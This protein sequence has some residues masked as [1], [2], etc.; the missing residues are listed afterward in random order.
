MA[1]GA[2]PPLVPVLPSSNR[3]RIASYNIR[4]GRRWR[5]E[6]A[7]R[8]MEQMDVGLGFLLEAKITDG[9]YTRFSSD[10]HVV[11]TDAP[12]PHQGGIALFYKDSRRWHIESVRRHGSNVI[13][14]VLVT[15]TRR[16]GLVGAYV[17]PSDR[18]TL[19]FVEAA[20]DR[21]PPDCTPVVLGDLNVDLDDLRDDR[22]HEI[23][24]ALTTRN[25]EDLLGHF[26]QRHRYRHCQ[27]WS[28]TRNGEYISSRCDYILCP[29]RQFFLNT[30]LRSPRLFDSDYLL[31]LA[32]LSLLP[33]D[34]HR[35]YT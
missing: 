4:N 8:A 20:L 33:L 25:F 16:F 1:S 10:Y 28:Q 17:P 6:S 35:A 30:A 34:Q 9:A 18:T 7:L 21:L 27:T 29:D 32:D 31:I 11:A 24:T 23:A 2:E 12:S 26:R 3:V 15:G 5:L 14:C 13:S 22:D 19:G